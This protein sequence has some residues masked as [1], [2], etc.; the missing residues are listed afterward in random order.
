MLTGLKKTLNW[1]CSYWVLSEQ[2]WEQVWKYLVLW[3]L[4]HTLE[5][6]STTLQ[7]VCRLWIVTVQLTMYQQVNISQPLSYCYSSASVYQLWCFRPFMSPPS[8]NYPKWEAT[9]PKKFV[10]LSS[11]KEVSSSVSGPWY[12]LLLEWMISSCCSLGQWRQNLGSF[13][14]VDCLSH[15]LGPELRQTEA[16]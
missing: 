4:Y 7:Q 9:A 3:D 14:V 11:L 6:P 16:Q 12:P 13:Q 10:L 5:P 15:Q 2:N 8:Q 1:Y